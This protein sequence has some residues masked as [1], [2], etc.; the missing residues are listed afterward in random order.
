[1]KIALCQ[2]NP[3]IGNLDYNKEKIVKGYKRGTT[4]KA[5]LVIFPELSLVGY[6]P[7]DL[8]EKKRIPFCC[9]QKN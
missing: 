9:K 2:I 8:V 6:P 1:M 4:A 3:I 5:D 7:L